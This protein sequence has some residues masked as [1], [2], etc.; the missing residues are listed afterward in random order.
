MGIETA[1]IAGLAVSAIAT[2]IGVY[3]G[4]QQAQSAAALAKYN[5]DVQTQQGVAAKEEAN[6]AAQA[7]RTRRESVLASIRARQ[8]ESGVTGVGSP[9]DTVSKEAKT[10][11]AEALDM[12]RQGQLAQAGYNTR[13][14]ISQLQ[15]QS[16]RRTGN[17][18]TATSLTSGLGRSFDI[19][20]QL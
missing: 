3:S 15:G 17:L 7:H 12:Q 14:Q 16:A 6:A 18:N 19:I 11:E 10:F 5:A 4:Q 9:L 1:L 13:A 2:G 20:T 8:A